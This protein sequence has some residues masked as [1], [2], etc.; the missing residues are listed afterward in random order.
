MLKRDRLL[1]KSLWDS[2]WTTPNTATLSAL[3]DY[4]E[5]YVNIVTKH[6]YKRYG[7]NDFDFDDFYQDASVGLIES[8]KRYNDG[9][10]VDFL[11]YAS[12][13]I[14]GAILN[15]IRFTTEKANCY[16]YKQ[17]LYKE[18]NESL[19]QSDS[20]LALSG[21][22]KL[23]AIIIQLAYSHMLDSL[24]EY[25]E[26]DTLERESNNNPYNIHAVNQL[27]KRLLNKLSTLDEP[28]KSVIELHYF[29]HFK[30]DDISNFLGVTKGRV[31]QIHKSAL[32]RLQIRYRQDM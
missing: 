23:R 7:F 19:N 21:S 25:F 16:S 6:M 3:T 1:E 14:Q 17:G 18:R 15:G 31:S 10:H 24:P 12:H 11:S 4:F 8:I 2:Y 22:E 28:E 5:P 9:F 30:F 32:T 29:G 13:R 20:K 26:G 27:R